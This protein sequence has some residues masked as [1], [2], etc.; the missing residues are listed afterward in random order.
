MSALNDLELIAAPQ[1]DLSV[2]VTLPDS[3]SIIPTHLSVSLSCISGLLNANELPNLLPAMPSCESCSKA[4]G[5]VVVTGGA[6]FGRKRDSPEGSQ[7][8][9]SFCARMLLGSVFFDT[10][11][12]PILPKYSLAEIHGLCAS[13]EALSQCL[14]A[15]YEKNFE[16]LK[17]ISTGVENEL[18]QLSV[19]ENL[20][21][22]IALFPVC[23]LGTDYDGYEHGQ[24][25]CKWSYYRGQLNVADT[26]YT[27]FSPYHKWYANLD[28]DEFIVN[29]KAYLQSSDEPFYRRAGN[30][31]ASDTFDNYD[32][33]PGRKS[34]GRLQIRWLDFQ[35]NTEQTRDVTVSV[36]EHGGLEFGSQAVSNTSSVNRTECTQPWKRNSGKPV[37]SCK[38]GGFGIRIHSSLG[39]SDSFNLSSRAPNTPPSF[40]DDIFL[41]HGRRETRFGNCVWKG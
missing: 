31:R 35:T 30:Q 2:P 12:V 16:F 36:L 41:Y 33:N 22:K 26:S 14:S 7:E 5:S 17:N 19:P 10:V 11:A 3:P 4:Q 40:V 38:D 1:I 13:Q 15:H 24:D 9:A 34:P 6:V 37:V 32:S 29:E 21:E 23:R 18:R 27:L 20:W 25:G 28:L 39:I 8:I